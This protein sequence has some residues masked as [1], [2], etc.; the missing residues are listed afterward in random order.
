M[1]LDYFRILVWNPN[2]SKIPTGQQA[3]ELEENKTLFAESPK[4]MRTHR[5][6]FME[7]AAKTNGQLRKLTKSEEEKKIEQLK[8]IE[9]IKPVAVVPFF[10]CSIKRINE[11]PR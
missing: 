4:V 11:M 6:K 9:K 7:L 2:W 3:V 10:S 1:S 5:A 8:D